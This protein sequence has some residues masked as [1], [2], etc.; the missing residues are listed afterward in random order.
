MF[1]EKVL[2]EVMELFPSKY[3]HIGGDECPKS[4]WAACEA[5]QARLKAEGLSSEDQLQTYFIKIRDEATGN[6]SYNIDLPEGERRS[7]GGILI[8]ATAQVG[9][10]LTWARVE[11]VSPAS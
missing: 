6:G 2:D 9:K 1:L 7:S 8:P 10:R 4:R 3:V 5:C 11:A